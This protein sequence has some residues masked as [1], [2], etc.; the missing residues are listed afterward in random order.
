MIHLLCV[1]V[2]AFSFFCFHASA[3]VLES[4]RALRGCFSAFRRIRHGLR[5]QAELRGVEGMFLRHAR[6]VRRMQSSS[7]SLKNG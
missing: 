6:S 1:D 7:S 4:P 2:D 3:F 5:A